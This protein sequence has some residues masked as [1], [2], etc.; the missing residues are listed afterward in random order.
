MKNSTWREYSGG[1]LYA[2]ILTKMSKEGKKIGIEAMLEAGRWLCRWCQQ[3]NA[4]G[5][6]TCHS[7]QMPRADFE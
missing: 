1:K 6:K 7:C 3:F 5:E 4:I 2:S